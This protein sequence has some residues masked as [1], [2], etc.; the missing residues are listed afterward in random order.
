MVLQAIPVVG[1]E[2]STKASPQGDVRHDAH[3]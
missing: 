1:F 2:L 3:G